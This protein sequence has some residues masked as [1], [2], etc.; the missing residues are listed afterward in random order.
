MTDPTM[1]I[2]AEEIKTVLEGISDGGKISKEAS[3]VIK[4]R[5]KEG[6]ERGLPLL[7]V[8][9]QFRSTVSAEEGVAIAAA[10][11]KLWYK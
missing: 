2:T 6:R 8:K 11:D 5:I 4:K 7:E 3:A 10:V 9:R 1:D